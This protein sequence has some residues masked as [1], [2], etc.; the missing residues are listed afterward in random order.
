LLKILPDA[1][2]RIRQGGTGNV[3]VVHA[4]AKSEKFLKETDFVAIPVLPARAAT[5]GEEAEEVPDLELLKPEAIWAAPAAWC[6]HPERTI[7]LRVKGNSMS[8]L[9]LDGYIIAVDTSTVSRDEMLGQI[10]WRDTSTRNGC[11][12]HG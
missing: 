3:Q 5:P 11:L 1:R 9:I 7:S 12:A 4:G 10:V 8:P 2:R 6:P